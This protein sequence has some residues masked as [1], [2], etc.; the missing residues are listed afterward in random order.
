MSLVAAV[1]AVTAHFRAIPLHRSGE[2]PNQVSSL[3]A[4]PMQMNQTIPVAHLSR[5]EQEK[6]LWIEKPN[7]LCFGLGNITILSVA[8]DL[9]KAYLV[10]LRKNRLSYA[11]L[12]GYRYCE[13][14]TP[15]DFSRP[16]PWTK[17]KAM[18]LLL[19]FAETVVAMEADAIVRNKTIR[20]ESI[21]S[22]EQYNVSGK[23]VIY[24]SDYQQSHD[25]DPD[26]K[27]SINTG[28]YIMRSSPWTKAFLESQYR[29]HT[30]SIFQTSNLEHDAVKVYR[31]KNKEDFNAHVA[32]IP[33]RFMNS[34]CTW[35]LD[36]YEDGDFI[37]HYAEEH[38]LDK[39][40]RLAL[41]LATMNL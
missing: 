36:K 26:P 28:V 34:P 12:H 30:S 6:L 33:F 29:L 19:S 37:A 16:F 32:I 20:V 8:I 3:Q 14:R 18:M 24:T 1:Y 31:M 41:Q 2:L 7:S 35:D 11:A 9:P 27:S 4:N 22:L 23:D 5:A 40:E 21:L 39:Y 15:L 38:S 13:V 17:V 25:A 10:Q